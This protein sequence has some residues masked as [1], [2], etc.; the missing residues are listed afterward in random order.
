MWPRIWSHLLNKSL[1]KNFLQCFIPSIPLLICLADRLTDF[2]LKRTLN[3]IVKANHLTCFYMKGILV[4]KVSRPLS[5]EKFRWFNY[6]I[7]SILGKSDLNGFN[8]RTS[9]KL[10]LWSFC[11]SLNNSE[12]KDCMFLWW[13][14]KKLSVLSKSLYEQS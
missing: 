12:A 2:F 14:V 8:N 6:V 11:L 7:N 4:A 1:I 13:S 10:G 5:S 3:K 9:E